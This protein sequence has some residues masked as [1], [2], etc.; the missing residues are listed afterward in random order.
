M[1]EISSWPG[2]TNDLALCPCFICIDIITGI[3]GI[4]SYERNADY[5]GKLCDL[6]RVAQMR[7][8]DVEVGGTQSPECSLE[9]PSLF[10]SGNP[11]LGGLKLMRIWNLGTPS[12]FLVRLPAR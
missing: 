4:R 9:L 5:C 8:L 12:K 1:L 2:L 3:N 7:V 6:F 11:L 10:V